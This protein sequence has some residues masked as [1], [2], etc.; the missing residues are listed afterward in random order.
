MKPGSDTR[1]E[2]DVSKG[3]TV[4]AGMG[5]GERA[6]ER[7]RLALAEFARIRDDPSSDP[8]IVACDVR[9]RAKGEDVSA[10]TG[11]DDTR[12]SDL[13]ERIADWTNVRSYFV[14]GQ[15]G[16]P[17]TTTDAYVVY[18]L[19]DA[20]GNARTIQR[21]VILNDRTPPQIFPAGDEKGDGIPY[22]TAST[23]FTTPRRLQAELQGSAAGY[24]DPGAVI[25][26]VVDG[27]LDAQSVLKISAGP[28][29]VS[30]WNDAGAVG[31][32]GWR[33]NQRWQPDRPLAGG[34]DLTRRGRYKVVYT[35][36]DKSGNA[37]SVVRWIVVE[38]T[39]P[40]TMQLRWDG[41]D[42]GHATSSGDPTVGVYNFGVEWAD[43]GWVVQDNNLKSEELDQNV[44]INSLLGPVPPNVDA[45][46]K[47]TR[48]TA[49]VLLL[50]SLPR[51]CCLCL[52]RRLMLT[53]VL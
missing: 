53:C 4:S 31:G 13:S 14:G 2:F 51:S 46:K 26:D 5:A 48:C 18:T 27:E 52:G 7:E 19:A 22:A 42:G 37:G 3:V 38:D 47:S 29:E 49:H 34:V 36:E 23:Q 24:V 35:A 40:P 10:G 30:D 45:S 32:K 25:E 6:R 50:N 20:K 33:V 43:P 8:W 44:A 17:L 16:R 9:D 15:D 21:S 1:I 28:E 11:A 12:I 41:S 39:T